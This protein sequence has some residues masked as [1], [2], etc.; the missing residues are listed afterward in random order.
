[1]SRQP[2]IFAHRGARIAAP[3]NT[4]AAFQS[5]LDMGADGI[6]LDVHCNKDG[7]L[8]VIHDFDVDGTTDG[9]GLVSALTTAE[10]AALNA[11][12]HFDGTFARTAVPT[13]AQVFDLVGDRCQVNVEIKSMDMNGG[14][15]IEPVLAMIQDRNLFD[16]VIISSFNPVSLIKTRWLEK[17]VA[18]GV[19]H[20][21]PLPD[22]L[23]AA[24][25]GPIIQPQAVHPLYKLVDDEYMAWA[26]A[27]N[28]AVNTWT[29]NNS[30]EARRLT[31][32]GVDAL[33]T[34]APDQII[35]ALRWD[36]ERIVRSES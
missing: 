11:S 32:L 1:M 12:A 14:D 24:W 25:L 10:L 28:C 13:L 18:L 2:Q 22:Y 16:Q 23:R 9:H 8:V 26:R 27:V 7:E 35:D 20:Y 4:L 3:E 34:D 5:A 31:D 15:Q 36:E 19:L 33:M 17:R 29:V 6:E 21:R 30:A